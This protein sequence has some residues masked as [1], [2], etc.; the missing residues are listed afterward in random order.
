MLLRAPPPR[1]TMPPTPMRAYFFPTSGLVAGTLQ[2][3]SCAAS[4]RFDQ[5]ASSEGADGLGDGDGTG[6]EARAVVAAT[7][8]PAACAGSTSARSEPH[9]IAPSAASATIA[10]GNVRSI[11]RQVPMSGP[12][13]HR[14][15]RGAHVAP[16]ASE[17]VGGA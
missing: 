8:S 15:R 17:P 4:R 10:I 9:P 13:Y 5:P 12:R 11:V 1:M 3:T 6:E 14:R 7:L 16:R 2:K